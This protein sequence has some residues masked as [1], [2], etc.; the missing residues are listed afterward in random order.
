[1]THSSCY[2]DGTWTAQTKYTP[3]MG[4]EWFRDRKRVVSWSKWI[5]NEHVL[6]KHQFVGWLYAH[7]AIRTKDKLLSYGLEIDDSCFLCNQAAESS[8]HLWCDC[9]YS[10]QVV[11]GL[12][13][14][15]KIVFPVTEVINWCTQLTGTVMQKGVHL[16]LVWGMVYHIWQQ[17]NKSRM[18]GILMR[19]EKIVSQI[20]E[21]VK[22][23][24]RGRD[25]KM[26]TKMDLDWLQSKE[27]YVL[28][29]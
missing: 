14:R 17:R 25:F 9:I 22:A 27:L 18:E 28:E 13:Q 20:I 6:P 7:G 5:W 1:M 3:A 19:P 29:T 26:I 12:S 2:T 24:I 10:R 16:G 15:L 8:D 21:E 4:Y 11:Q 23:R